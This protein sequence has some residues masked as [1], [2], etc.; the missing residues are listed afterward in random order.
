MHSLEG[1]V[2][3]LDYSQKEMRRGLGEL[4]DTIR[5]TGRELHAAVQQVNDK[6][7]NMAHADEIAQ[8]VAAAIRRDRHRRWT[9]G[10][11]A[12]AATV[13]ALALIPSLHVAA[14]WVGLA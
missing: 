10:R 7:D 8:N 5:D 9:A 2:A 13:A 11:K 1:T 14:A 3:G 12:A 6:V 4:R